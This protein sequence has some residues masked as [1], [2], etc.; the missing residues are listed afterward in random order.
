[1]RPGIW[2]AEARRQPGI[3]SEAPV[4]VAAK[5]EYAGATVALR[6]REPFLDQQGRD[7]LPSMRSRYC[8]RRETQKSVR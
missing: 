8:D 3:E 1:M 7:A 4:V 2:R 6:A 5:N